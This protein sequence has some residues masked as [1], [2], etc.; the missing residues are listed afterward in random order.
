MNDD[1]DELGT[2][3]NVDCEQK[4]GLFPRSLMMSQAN[5]GRRPRLMQFNVV[6]SPLINDTNDDDK[7]SILLTH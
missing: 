5:F 4:F 3:E 7:P 6:L 1:D 2:S